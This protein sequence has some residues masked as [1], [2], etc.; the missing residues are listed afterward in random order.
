M[1]EG[2]WNM[3][4]EGCEEKASTFT[5]EEDLHGKIEIIQAEL[6]RM[7]KEKKPGKAG[8]QAWVNE[9]DHKIDKAFNL[10]KLKGQYPEEE[11]PRL[12]EVFAQLEAVAKKA[13]EDRFRYGTNMRLPEFTVG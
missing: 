12:K 9:A 11:Y 4:I 8:A 2:G 5:S 6:E 3:V 10:L 13:D 1:T 7:T